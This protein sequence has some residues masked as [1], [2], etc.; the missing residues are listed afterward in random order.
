MGLVTTRSLSD[1]TFACEGGDPLGLK[2]GEE[3]LLIRFEFARIQL[4]NRIAEY[5][6]G[7]VLPC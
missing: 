5:Q 7:T 4:S 6:G 2:R 1:A 3:D